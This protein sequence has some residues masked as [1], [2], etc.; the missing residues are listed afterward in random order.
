MSMEEQA[1]SRH[2]FGEIECVSTWAMPPDLR[3]LSE[4]RLVVQV[5]SG[6]ADQLHILPERKVLYNELQD[7]RSWDASSKDG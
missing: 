3:K 7:I 6:L 1:W 2:G 5:Q 4:N